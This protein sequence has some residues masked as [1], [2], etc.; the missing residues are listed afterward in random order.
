M[1]VSEKGY[2]A[3]DADREAHVRHGLPALWTSG[4]SVVLQRPNG[5]EL[6]GRGMRQSLVLFVARGRECLC[7]WSE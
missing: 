5:R 2:Q 4:L 7:S 6:G 1:M 3:L